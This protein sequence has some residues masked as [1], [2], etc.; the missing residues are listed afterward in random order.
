MMRSQ[1]W[2]QVR[3]Q[4][5]GSSEPKQVQREIC[6]QVWNQ[7]ATQVWDQVNTQIQRQV[8]IHIYNQFSQ[9]VDKW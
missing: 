1:V 4:V 8:W 5:A 3:L 6:W 7:T 2:D 9:E